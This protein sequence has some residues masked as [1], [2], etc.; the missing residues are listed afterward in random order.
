MAEL[1]RIEAETNL[2]QVLE[3]FGAVAVDQLPYA[4]A[5]ALRKTGQDAVKAVRRRLPHA[6]NLRSKSLARTFGSD[7]FVDKKAWPNQRVRVW[8]MAEAMYLQEEGGIKRA[9]RGRLAVPT[10]MVKRSPSTGKIA[11]SRRPRGLLQRKNAFVQDDAIVQR[12][13]KGSVPLRH[14]SLIDSARIKPILGFERT[15]REV[16]D[17][18]LQRRLVVELGRAI[19][20]RR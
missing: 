3:R 16:V 17:R 18:R 20:P 12:K 5:Q 9:K 2:E 15:V 7:R 8:T 1:I 10:R 4:T 13:R 11:K 14:Y 6:F 19:A